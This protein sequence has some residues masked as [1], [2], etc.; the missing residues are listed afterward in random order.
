MIKYTELLF[1]HKSTF[2]GNEGRKMQ[3]GDAFAIHDK[4]HVKQI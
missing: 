3:H 4:G 2:T 1:V